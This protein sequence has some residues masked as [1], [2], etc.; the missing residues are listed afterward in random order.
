MPSFR[1]RERQEEAY[2][3]Q[4]SNYPRLTAL[5]RPHIESFNSIFAFGPSSLLELAVSD[6]GSVVVFSQG[7][8]L[9]L[10]VEGVSVGSPTLGDSARG[11]SSREIFPAECRERQTTYR[12]RIQATLCF[13]L[14]GGQVTREA[15]NLG[16]MPIMVRVSSQMSKLF[17][18]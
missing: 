11:T 16:H 14:D 15:R 3:P 13:R 1:T 4:R 6:V 5:S 10:W 18:W 12:A 8:K 17:Y 2:A 9:E 7:R